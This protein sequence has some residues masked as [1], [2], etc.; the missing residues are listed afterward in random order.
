MKRLIYLS[1]IISMLLVLTGSV[2]KIQHWPGAGIMLTLGLGS[3]VLFFVPAALVNNYKANKNN[4]KLALYLVTFLVSLL[5]YGGALFKIMHWPGA[6][7]L[8]IFT[9]PLPFCLFVPVFLYSTSKD[10]SF[11]II[12][13]TIILLFIAYM[14]VTTAMLALSYS[15]N[16]LDEGVQLDKLLTSST[17]Q[18]DRLNQ[19]KCDKYGLSRGEEAGMKAFLS[20]DLRGGML[21]TLGWEASEIDSLLIPGTSLEIREMD[22]LQP[23]SEVLFS[24]LNY[25]RLAEIIQHQDLGKSSPDFLDE[26]RGRMYRR[27]GMTPMIFSMVMLSDLELT[28]LVR[29]KEQLDLKISQN[30][31]EP[32]Q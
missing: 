9:I 27:F 21:R 17:E 26:A 31:P 6:G 25:P 2:F 3:L 16:I 11:S 32:I 4:G 24:E 15:R 18:L 20:E 22:N 1:G 5:V 13:T 14:G 30:T 7:I 28:L 23:V 12:N 10:K 19:Q 29:E 8:L